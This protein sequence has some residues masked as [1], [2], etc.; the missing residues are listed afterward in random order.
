MYTHVSLYTHVYVNHVH[1]LLLGSDVE[2]QSCCMLLGL[3]FGM[4]LCTDSG[5][6]VLGFAGMGCSGNGGGGARN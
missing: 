5:F 2:F 6:R 4:V 1:L 3:A